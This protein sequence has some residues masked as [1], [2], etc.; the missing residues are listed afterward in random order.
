MG[1]RKPKK[2]KRRKKKKDGEVGVAYIGEGVKDTWEGC[3]VGCPVS[4]P[5]GEL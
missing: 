1:R 3:L 5:V 2:E 4:C